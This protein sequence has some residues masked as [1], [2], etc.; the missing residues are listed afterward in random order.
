MVRS[1]HQGDESHLAGMRATAAEGGRETVTEAP[2]SKTW[3]ERTDE[4]DSQRT[5]A[6]ADAEDGESLEGREERAWERGQRAGERPR[7]K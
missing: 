7:A 5:D 1:A 6:T 3:L 2:S 4:E